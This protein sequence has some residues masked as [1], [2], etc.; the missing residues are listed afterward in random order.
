MATINRLL[1]FREGLRLRQR[2][3][4]RRRRRRF[5]EGIIRVRRLPPEFEAD[6]WALYK[7]LWLPV[8]DGQGRVLSPAKLSDRDK[9]R[10]TEEV[11]AN[12]VCVGGRTQILT[13]IGAQTGGTPA[14]T[15]YFAVGTG[16]PVSPSASD[17]LSD[18]SNYANEIFRK[19]P[20]SYAVTG[21][22]V[23][24]SIPFG[25]ADAQA[26]WTN[27]GI[28][29]VSATSSGNTGVLMTHALAPY[30][31]GNF[32]INADYVVTLFG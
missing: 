32:A 14:F 6:N 20:A 28:F 1:L 12:V 25:S 13:F 30:T 3:P 9:E 19:A 17:T 27:C 5:A 29:G 2:L 22:Q 16:S 7:D 21:S 4:W 15:Q 8:T 26:T 24:I 11:F 31:K 23:D 10:F 18:W